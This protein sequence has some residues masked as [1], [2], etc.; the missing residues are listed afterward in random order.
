MWN[1]QIWLHFVSVPMRNKRLACIKME[2]SRFS[3]PTNCRLLPTL[4]TNKRHDRS[5]LCTIQAHTIYF[6]PFYNNFVWYFLDFLCFSAE[7]IMMSLEGKCS[8]WTISFHSMNL[9]TFSNVSISFRRG[10]HARV[11]LPQMCNMKTDAMNN[12]DITSTGTGPTLI[13]GES[14]V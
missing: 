7:D 9:T 10:A 12:N 11:Y 1:E 14:S 8:P 4:L 3:F 2:V 13:P 6:I 5:L